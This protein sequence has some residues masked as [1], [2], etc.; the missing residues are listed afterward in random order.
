MYV[1]PELQRQYVFLRSY[2]GRTWLV[3]ANFSDGTSEI[4][5]NIPED[6]CRIFGIKASTVCVKV[7]A[8]DGVIKRVR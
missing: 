7:N 1:N 5:V 3:V 4:T 8:W 2:E 6:A